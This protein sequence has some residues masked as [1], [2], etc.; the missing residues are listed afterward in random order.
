MGNDFVRVSGL[1]L[2]C[3]TTI[4]VLSDCS[5]NDPLKDSLTNFGHFFDAW[6]SSIGNEFEGWVGNDFVWETG[7]CLGCFTTFFVLSD[8][9]FNDP[10]KDPLT[11]FGHDFDD[12]ISSICDDFEGWIGFDFVRVSALCSGCFTPFFVLSDCSLDRPL[13]DPRPIHGQV[14]DAWISSIG[15]DFVGSIGN[16]FVGVSWL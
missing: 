7:L 1:C 6:I 3:F 9:S 4:F 10:L 11:N 2:G 15:N 13:K 14:F 16:D 5:F 8:C 12:L